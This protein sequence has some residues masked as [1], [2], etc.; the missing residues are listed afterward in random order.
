MNDKIK[1][2]V[3]EMTLEQKVGQLFL[4]GFED[5]DVSDEEL[6]LFKECHF[7]N[8]MYFA[9]NIDNHDQVRKLSKRLNDISMEITG[10][11]PFIALD[12]EGGMVARIH[13]GCTVFPSSMAITAAGMEDKMQEYGRMAGEELHRMGINMNFAPC[14]DINNNPENPVIGIRSFSDKPE[15]VAQMGVDYGLGLQ[16]AGVAAVGKHFPGHG[17]TAV[18]SHLGLPVINYD[19]ERLGKV[20]LVPFKAAIEKGLASL[21]SAHI[22]FSSI[23]DSGLPGTLSPYIINDFLRGELGFGGVVI[24]DSLGMKAVEKKYGTPRSAAMAV[25]AGADLLCICVGVDI[26]RDAYKAVLDAVASGEITKEQIDQAVGRILSCKAQYPYE[27][28]E[29]SKAVYPQN[30][31]L[32]DEMGQRS[33][34]L[35]R[36]AKGYMPITGKRNLIISPAP[37]RASLIDDDRKYSKVSFAEYAEVE[38]GGKGVTIDVDPDAETI[39]QIV[40]MAKDYD[41]VIMASYNAKLFPKQAELVNRLHDVAD[42]LVTVSLRI[43]YDIQA[44]DA[45]DCNIAAYEYTTRSIRNVVKVLKGDLKPVG[46]LP[47]DMGE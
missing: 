31:A 38:M 3:A 4:V 2:Q 43:P 44:Y 30:E 27:Y 39:N 15:V 36:D 46:Q 42:R 24:T 14:L 9:R 11:S 1:R 20:E 22:L 17:D 47:V 10:L 25:K 18:D 37:I 5:V 23:D 45:V 7:G 41:T 34:T 33:I 35:M 21:M 19:R 6:K 16:S 12:Q 32:A 26:M 40:A 29:D 13:N 8:Y 28:F